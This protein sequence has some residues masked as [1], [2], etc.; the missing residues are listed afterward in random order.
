[1]SLA[2]SSPS[3]WLGSSWNGSFFA[4]LVSP[5]TH[6]ISLASFQDLPPNCLLSFMAQWHYFH[7]AFLPLCEKSS[8]NCYQ[9]EFPGNQGCLN[10]PRVW[11]MWWKQFVL[12]LLLGWMIGHV[13]KMSPPST[14]LPRTHIAPIYC[15]QWSE[16]CKLYMVLLIQT[17]RRSEKGRI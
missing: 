9:W 15:H 6:I 8:L 10:Y 5:C 7:L 13:A 2:F 3:R 12:W 1:M 11:A 14:S 4:P 16:P 17:H